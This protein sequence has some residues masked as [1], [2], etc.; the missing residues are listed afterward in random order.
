MNFRSVGR[1]A[2]SI[3]LLL[4]LSAC[5]GGGAKVETTNT[6]TTMGQELMDLDA[7]YKKGLLTEDEYNSARENIM[8]RYK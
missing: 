6:T 1:I 7:S 3:V 8:K 5:G 4:V 2:L